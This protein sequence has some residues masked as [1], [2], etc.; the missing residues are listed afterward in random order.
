MLYHSYFCGLKGMMPGILEMLEAVAQ[1]KGM[2]WKE[3][4]THLKEEGQLH[5]EVY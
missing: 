3:K 5:V 4:L 1:K 2:D